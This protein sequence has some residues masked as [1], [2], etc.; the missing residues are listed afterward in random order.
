VVSYVPRD[1]RYNSWAGNPKGNPR[2]EKRCWEQVHDSGRGGL[3][4]QCPRAW[5]V[6]RD[7]E[8]FCKQHD[9]V[10]VKARREAS[11]QGWRDVGAR[12]ELQWKRES[13]KAA[14]VKAAM[15]WYRSGNATA[16][17]GEFAA[18][19]KACEKLTVLDSK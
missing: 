13:A 18:L 3:F 8:R 2:D 7:G 19:V 11:E 14:V 6:E 15:A 10:V 4:Y 16:P 9:P 1:G 17:Q 12:R 5:K